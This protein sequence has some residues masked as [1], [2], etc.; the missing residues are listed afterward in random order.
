MD[1]K[2][3]TVR[4]NP[5]EII[6][7]EVSDFDGER[8]ASFSQL[9][10]DSFKASAIRIAKE[11]KTVLDELAPDEGSI[12]FGLAASIESGTLTG[13]L[14]KGTGEANVK[15]TLRWGPRS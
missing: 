10:F 6:H 11:M 4:I 12:E 15:I 5:G 14:A 3:V 8:N 13:F 9:D 7:M 1:T 2:L